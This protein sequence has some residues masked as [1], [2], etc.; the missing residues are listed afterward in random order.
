MIKVFSNDAAPT[1]EHIRA[2]QLMPGSGAPYRQDGSV[3]NRFRIKSG[4]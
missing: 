3:R 2:T 4:E 1:D